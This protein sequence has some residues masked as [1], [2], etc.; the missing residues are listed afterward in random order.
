MTVDDSHL[1]LC[2]LTSDDKK[3]EDE[4]KVD[5]WRMFKILWRQVCYIPLIEKFSTCLHRT[6]Y[7][8][9]FCRSSSR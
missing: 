6:H 7:L 5:S 1:E 2:S 9:W 3:E 4:R 8:G